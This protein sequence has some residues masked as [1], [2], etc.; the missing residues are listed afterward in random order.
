MPEVSSFEILT[1][2][3]MGYIVSKQNNEGTY[4]NHAPTARIKT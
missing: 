1:D 2:G 3:I 4:V